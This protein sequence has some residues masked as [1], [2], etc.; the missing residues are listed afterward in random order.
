VL[1]LSISFTHAFFGAGSG[2]LTW[3]NAGAYLGSGTFSGF[4]FPWSAKVNCDPITGAAF[5]FCW[6]HN[7]NT[8]CCDTAG[9]GLAITS[10]TCTDTSFLMT[11]A[12]GTINPDGFSEYE[13][14]CNDVA[15]DGGFTDWTITS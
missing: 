8:Y 13:I 7:G 1:T 14:E 4:L 5:T 15:G 12:P 9:G 3:D 10:L 2:T 6:F 11:V